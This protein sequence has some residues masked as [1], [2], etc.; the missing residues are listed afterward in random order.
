MQSIFNFII[1]PIGGRYDNKKKVGD[2]E[3]IVNTELQNHNFVNIRTI[4]HTYKAIRHVWCM[5]WTMPFVR[6]ALESWYLNCFDSEIP[7]LDTK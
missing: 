7:C 6:N 2:K 3:L 5:G 1:E 4:F